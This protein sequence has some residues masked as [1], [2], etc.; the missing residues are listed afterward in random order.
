MS[1][2]DFLMKKIVI[3]PLSISI[4]VRILNQHFTG[5]T[6]DPKKRERTL[7]DRE[8]DFA[9]AAKVFEGFHFTK[10]DTRKDYGERRFISLGA[11]QGLLIVLV[12][13]NRFSSIHVIS[14]RRA[15]SRERKTYEVIHH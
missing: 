12:W 8:L 1:C 10:E 4:N 14:M 2:D 11:I 13:T 9:Q 15:N 7:A 6:F 3:N 5:L